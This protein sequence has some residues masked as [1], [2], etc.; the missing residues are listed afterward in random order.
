MTLDKEIERVGRNIKLIR[1]RRYLKQNEVAKLCQ[2]TSG[3]MCLVE[4]GK[5]DIPTSTLIKLSKIFKCEVADFFTS[6]AR[7]EPLI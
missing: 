4:Q 7:I 1:R 2:C 3:T 6:D 5:I